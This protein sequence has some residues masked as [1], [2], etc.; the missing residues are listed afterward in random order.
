[1][2]GVK[3]NIVWQSLYQVLMIAVPLI[4][5]P[6]VSRVLGPTHMGVYSYYYTIATYFGFFIMLG[7]G[8]YGNKTIAKAGSDKKEVSKTFWNIYA[9]QFVSG[10]LCI[11]IYLF[12]QCNGENDIIAKIQILMLVSSMFDINW[13]FY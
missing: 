9:V 1:M 11:F 4:I 8:N 5:S 3:K 2:A 7:V 6:Y 13:L 12:S 10:V